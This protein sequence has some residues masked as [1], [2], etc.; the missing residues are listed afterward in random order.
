MTIRYTRLLQDEVIKMM[1]TKIAPAD[2]SEETTFFMSS[3]WPS[4]NLP[5]SDPSTSN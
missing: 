1:R 5:L 3:A 2:G 4:Y